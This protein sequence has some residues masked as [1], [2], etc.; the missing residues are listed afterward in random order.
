MSTSIILLHQNFN[1]NYV[2][3]MVFEPSVLSPHAAVWGIDD[4]VPFVIQER[5]KKKNFMQ[6]ME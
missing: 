2:D 3:M 5:Y 6:I 4:M 1:A